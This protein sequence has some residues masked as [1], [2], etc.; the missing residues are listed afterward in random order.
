[1][2]KVGPLFEPFFVNSSPSSLLPPAPF[3]GE[4][5]DYKENMWFVFE[6]FY[7]KIFYFFSKIPLLFLP[8]SLTRYLPTAEEL[9][10]NPEKRKLIPSLRVLIII[11][12]FSHFKTQSPFFKKKKKKKKKILSIL[13]LISF[14]LSF[15]P[16]L[17]SPS[18]SPSPFLSPFQ[19]NTRRRPTFFSCSQRINSS[20]T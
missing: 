15:P 20:R 2:K 14:S 7:E 17:P 8:F 9:W 1:M 12:S 6:L 4:S 3:V 19:W 11:R 5:L 13:I 10:T 18:L 16:L